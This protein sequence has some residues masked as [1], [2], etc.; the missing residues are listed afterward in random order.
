MRPQ[1]TTE[2][3]SVAEGHGTHNPA[4]TAHTEANGSGKAEFPP[5]QA[6]NFA[7]QLVSFAIAFVLLYVIVSRIALPRVGGLLADR[8]NTI[9]NDLAEA[10]KLKDESDTALKAYETELATARSRAQAI[11]NETRE[12]LSA[13]SEAER[14]ALE[15][16]LAEKLD[17]AEQSIAATRQTAMGNVRSIA[18][19][20]AAAIVQ[21]LTGAHPD[22]GTVEAA[23]DASL[24]G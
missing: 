4:T 10:Q 21:H 2:E 1:L 12:K 18:T 14:K 6:S 7:S 16:R 24:K 3:M 13:Q 20:A 19:D 9:D 22:G 5:F 11:G 15:Q 17:A 23:V 8:Q